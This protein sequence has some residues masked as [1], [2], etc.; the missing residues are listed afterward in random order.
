MKHSFQR[1]R[2]IA[3]L[4]PVIVVC[5]LSSGTNAVET[6]DHH[7]QNVL[8]DDS[9]L[10]ISCHDGAV[11]PYVRFCIVKCD[12]TKG[13]VVF[14]SYPPPGKEREF[15]PAAVAKTRGIIFERGQVTCISCHDIRKAR[16]KHLVTDNWKSSLCL[17]CHIH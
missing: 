9:R 4:I 10:C 17:S 1:Q 5:F 3:A 2:L 12:I 6:V 14:R 15:Q 16:P 8:A 11:G 13:H 7:G